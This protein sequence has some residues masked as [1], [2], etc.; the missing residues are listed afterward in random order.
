[1]STLGKTRNKTIQ[2]PSK[3]CGASLEHCG[4]Q[5]SDPN[6]SVDAATLKYAALRHRT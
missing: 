5:T 1:M 2:S 4:A 3:H 6:L